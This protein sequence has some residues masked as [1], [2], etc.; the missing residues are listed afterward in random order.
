MFLIISLL[1][2]IPNNLK[3]VM[4]ECEF[5]TEPGRGKIMKIKE[6][7]MEKRNKRI[8]LKRPNLIN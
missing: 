6:V 5:L 7:I 8:V 3:N 1:S 2:L 4:V